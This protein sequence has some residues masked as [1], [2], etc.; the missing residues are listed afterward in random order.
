M[1]DEFRAMTFARLVGDPLRWRTRRVDSFQSADWIEVQKLTK[2][3]IRIRR[4]FVLQVLDELSTAY[5]EDAGEKVAGAREK[6]R[7]AERLCHA[8][9]RNT[10][11]DPPLT[12]AELLVPVGYHDGPAVQSDVRV[13]GK[14]IPPLNRREAADVMARLFSWQL[15]GAAAIDAIPTE[16]VSGL[17]AATGWCLTATDTSSLRERGPL[18]RLGGVD[19]DRDFLAI[20]EWMHENYVG[21]CGC[22]GS[23][24]ETLLRSTHDRV[25]SLVRRSL[26]LRPFWQD[27]GCD[28]SSPEA[29]A[30]NPAANPLLMHYSY[31]KYLRWLE[32]R[33]GGNYV[34]QD[35]FASYLSCSFLGLCE[36]WMNLLEHV[37]DRSDGDDATAAASLG[38]ATVGFAS[39]IGVTW[40]MILRVQ[41]P[42]ERTIRVEASAA[43]PTSTPDRFASD[44]DL[45]RRRPWV[46]L[47]LADWLVRRPARGAVMF[48]RYVLRC[49]TFGQRGGSLSGL[50]QSYP[51]VLH[52][53]QSYHVEIVSPTAAL[54]LSPRGALVKIHE[55]NY[56][57][58][59]LRGLA[60]GRWVDMM[61]PLRRIPASSVFG[62]T[63]CAGTRAHHYYT[64]KTEGSTATG[65][66]SVDTGELPHL[67]VRY[68]V[69]PLLSWTNAIAAVSVL[70]AS[71]LMLRGVLFESLEVAPGG[72]DTIAYGRSLGPAILTVLLLFAF[73]RH[74]NM[75][76]SRWLQ[77]WVILT[78][79]AFAVFL[80]SL[81]LRAAVLD[82]GAVPVLSVM[83]PLA[84]SPLFD[85]VRSLLLNESAILSYTVGIALLMA[86][87]F[88]V[89]APL[90]W[91]ATT[92]VGIMWLAGAQLLHEKG[93][94]RQKGAR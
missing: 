17:W 69:K 81:M 80:V 42:L 35:D 8:L 87:L 4:A 36:C 31:V 84:S 23:S 20:R 19:A 39:R 10:L 57:Y 75:L 38:R 5:A 3:D 45:T 25:Y 18:S 73:E 54:E 33:S 52:D 65:A 46:W 77:R 71:L 48:W 12:T 50:T 88:L 94:R 29:M 55:R 6:L 56:G 1:A 22:G 79:I 72:L 58:P 28:V 60:A 66:D 63:T 7:I 9:G 32:R 91:L 62:R 59:R 93:R 85:G 70:G 92:A 82:P 15:D 51:L 40:P 90:L 13:D 34:L 83:G 44:Y 86:V 67:V 11:A 64:T 2:V 53:A 74:N 14:V 16:S 78:L 76:V 27:I 24:V 49:A 47:Q 43:L 30:F 37:A 21:S 41:I 89:L 61:F 26:G 68:R